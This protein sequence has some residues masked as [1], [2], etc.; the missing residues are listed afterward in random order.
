[1]ADQQP[2]T[3][4]A[5]RRAHARQTA[6][7]SVFASGYNADIEAFREREYPQLNGEP[8]LALLSRTSAGVYGG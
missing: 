4:S 5:L 3:R 8:T 7:K 1:M 6:L 2:A